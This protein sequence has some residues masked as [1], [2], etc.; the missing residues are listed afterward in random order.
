MG[1]TIWVEVRGRAGAES[2]QDHSIMLRLED[3]LDALSEELDVPK[4]SEF[5]DLSALEEAYAEV[6]D[7][8]GDSGDEP[9]AEWSAGSPAGGS[10]FDSARGLTAVRAIHDHLARHPEGLGFQPDPSQ[11]HWP[12]A[13]LDELKHCQ[14]VLEEAAA[15]GQEFRFLIVP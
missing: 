12:G 9:D 14:S 7:E 11:R 15:R 6:D 8:G 4:L 1:A 10:W 13:L 2:E 3:Q 5:Y